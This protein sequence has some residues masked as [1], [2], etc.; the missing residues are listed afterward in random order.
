[1]SF[2]RPTA[3]MSTLKSSLLIA[4]SRAMRRIESVGMKSPTLKMT[5]LRVLITA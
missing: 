2:K 5:L 3:T 4:M 1:M